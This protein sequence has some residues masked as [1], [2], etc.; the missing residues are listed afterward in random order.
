[1]KKLNKRFQSV[2]L[3]VRSMEE[4]CISACSKYCTPYSDLFNSYSIGLYEPTP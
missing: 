3:S 1:M 2:K 4:A